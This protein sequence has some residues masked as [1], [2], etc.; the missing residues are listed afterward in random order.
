VHGQTGPLVLE[1]D[2]LTLQGNISGAGTIVV[3][4]VDPGRGIEIGTGSTGAGTLN[5]DMATLAKLSTASE[6]VFGSEG[7]SGKVALGAVDFAALTS[8]P[9]TVHG[10]L[11]EVQAGSGVLRTGASLVLD[12]RNGVLVGDDIQAGGAVAIHSGAGLTMVAGTHVSGSGR[13]D[14]VAQGEVRIG[15]LQADLVVVDGSTLRGNGDAGT[16]IIARQVSLHGYGPLS[17][18]P[19]ALVIQ[20][21]SVHVAAMSGVL[22]Q[23]TDPDGRTHFYLLEGGK[24]YEQAVALGS[25]ERVTRDPAAA[26]PAQAF[27]FDA[28]VMVEPMASLLASGNWSSNFGTGTVTLG[29]LNSN[30]TASPAGQL[31]LLS[32]GSLGIVQGSAGQQLLS[33]GQSLAA[34]P[35]FEYWLEDLVI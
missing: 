7:M 4:T 22:V 5:I 35:D 19:G 33:T 23:D 26:Q 10:G 1:S 34:A 6:L 17:G 29:Y 16:S 8:A 21:P 24:M 30:V 11:V 27:G 13:I 9:V 25:V 32:A 14:V 31:G 15:Q 28:G 3:K 2:T 12:G 18:Q 20:S